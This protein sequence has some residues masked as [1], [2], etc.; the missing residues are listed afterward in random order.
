MRTHHGRTAPGA[1]DLMETAVRLL[2][3]TGAAGLAEYYIG[4]LPF[5]LGLLFFW[6]DMSR[7]PF[8]DDYLAPAA[9]GMALLF[10]WMKVWQVRFCRRLWSALHDSAPEPWPWQRCWRT[11][12]RQ[13]A[14]QATGL[15]VLPVAAL[16]VLPMAW[17]Y[18]FYQNLTVLDAPGNRPVKALSREAWQ[19]ALALPG[20]N[21]LLLTLISIFG[22]MVLLN[23]IIALILL[24]HLGKW[25][26]D[27]ESPFTISGLRAMTN[28]TFLT[29]VCALAY[30]CIDP[31]VKAAYTLRCFHIVTRNS[32]A[33]LRAAIKPFLKTLA[34]LVL[35]GA[36]AAVVSLPQPAAAAD[37]QTAGATQEAYARQLDET[38]DRVL[39]ERRF[40]WRLPREKPAAAMDEEPQGWIAGAFLWLADRI[41]E[42]LDALGR[43]IE[44]LIDWLIRRLPQS[45]ERTSGERDWRPLIRHLFYLTGALLFVLLLLVMWRWW[46]RTRRPV[47]HTAA[48][49]LLEPQVNIHDETLTAADLPS[50]RWQM[51]ARE[52]MAHN[53]LRAALRALYLAMLAQLGDT[54]HVAL[55]RFKSN[56]DYRNEL[57]RRAHV[58]PELL[59]CF[60]RCM[61]A[62]ERAWYG[63]HPVAET[64]LSS[65]I[66]DQER[67]ATLV[68]STA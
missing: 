34:L 22:L 57:D 10:I 26:L 27:I 31:L 2:R 41:E 38:I 58:E 40:A 53:D 8:A 61:T 42:G 36:M 68:Q 48:A 66:T 56:R 51:L 37:D 3:Q 14:V 52:L 15:V 50:D 19:Q 49:P 47:D 54:G 25:L 17:V 12:L 39:Q 29:T 13:A 9:G 5:L 62:F 59:A 64:Q 4:T 43:W 60:T 32:G 67:I 63:M 1:L 21:H 7:N 30:A 46:W 23:L 18:A 28:T 35:W 6:A 16:I 20:Q 33:D 65:F 55:A 11:A 24:P 45:E 44:A